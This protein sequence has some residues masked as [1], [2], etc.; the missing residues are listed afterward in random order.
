[1]LTLRPVPLLALTLLVLFVSVSCGGRNKTPDTGHSNSASAGNS[2]ASGL[3][4]SDSTEKIRIKTPDDRTLVEFKPGG[5]EMKIEFMANGQTQVLRSEPGKSD[6]RKYAIDNTGTI[7]EVKPDSDG[8][9]VRT[10]GGE[11]P[12]KVKISGDKIKISNNEENTHPFVLDRKDG[13][14]IKVLRD[15][16]QIGEVKFYHDERKVKVKD[17]AEKELYESDTDRFSA[18]YGVLLMPQITDAQR[19]II[20]AQLLARKL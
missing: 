8:F 15:E 1:M 18:M 13:E 16:A 4:V 20:M 10:P 5:D 6:K 7:A 14:R 19:Y 9:K 17:T 2:S 12:W 11:L 3:T